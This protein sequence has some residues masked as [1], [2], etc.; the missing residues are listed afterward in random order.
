MTIPL[1]WFVKKH[2]LLGMTR[3]SDIALRAGCSRQYVH[4]VLYELIAQG[5]A[6]KEKK[7]ATHITKPKKVLF[8]L[9]SAWRMP[10]PLQLSM[11]LKTR[12]ELSEF[13]FRIGVAHVFTLTG[14]QVWVEDTAKLRAFQGRGNVFVYCDA[15][16]VNSYG[17]NGYVDDVQRFCDFFSHDVEKALSFA[18]HKALLYAHNH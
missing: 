15:R 2:A 3:Q 4:E 18:K 9:A 8:S 12:A 13:L 5:L 7:N 14:L 17:L 6:R 16:V 11:P 10:N 1:S